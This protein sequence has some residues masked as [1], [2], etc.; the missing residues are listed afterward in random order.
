MGRFKFVFVV[1]GMCA[2]SFAGTPS[3]PQDPPGKPTPV[4]A[5]RATITATTIDVGRI[6]KGE[7]ADFEF[8]IRNTGKM[9][10]EVNAAP[11]CGCTVAK[12][13]RSIAPGMEGKICAALRTDMLSGRVTKVID[14]TTNDPTQPKVALMLS[15]TIVERIS[16][17]RAQGKALALESAATTSDQFIVRVDPSEKMQVTGVKCDQ[18]FAR[19]SFEALKEEPEQG[20]AYRVQVDVDSQAPLGRTKLTVT[21]A[22][23]SPTEATIPVEI[24]CEKGLIASPSQ[25]SFGVLTDAKRPA[26]RRLTVSRA[27]GGVKILK[28]ESDDPNIQPRVIESLVGSQILVIYRGGADEGLHKGTLRIE[29]DDLQQPLLEVP[30]LYRIG[31]SDAKQP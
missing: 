18:T 19:A 20:K 28:V 26:T 31:S 9:P 13:D 11:K 12:F 30:T 10:L 3:E 21:V 25:V 7:S 2:G 4:D 5:A 29:T 14:V 6:R 24:L 8:L 15:A 16:I 23:D 22:T 27:K 17:E 1:F